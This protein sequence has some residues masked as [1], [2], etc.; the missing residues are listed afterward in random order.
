M[1]ST[2]AELTQEAERR[3]MSGVEL[4]RRVGIAPETLSRMRQRGT[5]DF[6]T[7]ARM[8]EVLGYQISLL[9]KTGPITDV[10]KG[11]FFG[12]RGV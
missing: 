7:I 9:P 12:K 3:G 11:Q 4:A 8:A 2:L 1:L 10:L 6:A 5:G